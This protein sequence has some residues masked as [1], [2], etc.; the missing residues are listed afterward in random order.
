MSDLQIFSKDIIPVYTTDEGN[1]VV[2]GRELHE[3]LG[4]KTAY[5]DWLPRMVE[6]GFPEW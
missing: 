1:K 6:Y 5:K 2:M 4:I 3:K